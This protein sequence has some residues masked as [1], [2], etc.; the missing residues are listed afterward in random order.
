MFF[1]ML[2]RA[3]LAIAAPL[4]KA[5]STKVYCPGVGL[6]IDDEAQLVDSDIDDDD[7]R[8]TMPG[9]S[10]GSRAGNDRLGWK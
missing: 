3:E 7:D 8:A 9:T 1:W 10:S 2:P 4:Q 6:V 5:E